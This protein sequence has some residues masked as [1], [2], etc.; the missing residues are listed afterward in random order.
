MKKIIVFGIVF[1]L[2]FS[3]FSI[4]GAFFEDGLLDFT[5]NAM[6]FWGLFS[7]AKS[8]TNSYNVPVKPSV[9]TPKIVDY[10]N[11][12]PVVDS[13]RIIN[14][15]QKIVFLGYVDSAYNPICNVTGFLPNGTNLTIVIDRYTNITIQNIGNSTSN[16]TISLNST[17]KGCIKGC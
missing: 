2:M 11:Q 8:S 5:G 4:A 17:I 3:T 16:M 1:L 15:F 6:K 10:G 13:Q 7:G 12:M 9:T 14:R